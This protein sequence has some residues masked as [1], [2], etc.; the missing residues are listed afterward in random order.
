MPIMTA[1]R[2]N[3]TKG[4]R[5]RRRLLDAAAALVA[6][7]GLD[8]ISLGDIATEAGLKTGS[9]YFH[10]A[11]KEQ[12][13]ET[14]LEEGLIESLRHLDEALA[15]VP[16][17]AGTGARL[18]AAVH[19]HLEALLVLSH[20]ATV[21]LTLR[22]HTDGP[23]ASVYR[24]LKHRYGGQWAELIDDAQRSGVLPAELDPRTVRDLLFG[25]M[26]STL[27]TAGRAGRSPEEVTRTIKALLDRSDPDRPTGS[28]G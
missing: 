9:I 2:D 10:F 12:L 18:W 20:Y 5:T 15:T 28:T 16:D 21:V 17:D 24:K 25:A 14:V 11:S 4:D 27:G 1:A 19:A 26:N 22:E 8:A 23:A 7:H 6:R 13:I 3:V